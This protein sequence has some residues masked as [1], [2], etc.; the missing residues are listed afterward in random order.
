MT[1][2]SSLTWLASALTVLKLTARTS[3]SESTL[4]NVSG[5]FTREVALEVDHA[6]RR[7]LVATLKL[8]AARDDYEGSPRVD[9]RYTASA[10]VVYKLTRELQLKAEY[11]RE[12]LRSNTQGADYTADVV[13]FGLRLQ[14]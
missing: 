1:F 11:R 5:A 4:I 12:W 9:D 3:V 7:W 10:A 6:F 14:R 2:D 13:L 8:T